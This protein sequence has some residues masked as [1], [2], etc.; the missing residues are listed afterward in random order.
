MSRPAFG[1][2]FNRLAR[3][4]RKSI[5]LDVVDELP[6]QGVF[7]PAGPRTRGAPRC[8]RS[9]ARATNSARERLAAA[10]IPHVAAPA[11][12]GGKDKVARKPGW[13]SSSFNEPPCRRMTALARL[14]PRPKPGRVLLP[15]SRTKRSSTRSRS[16]PECPAHGRRPDL[17]VSVAIGARRDLDRGQRRSRRCSA[18]SP[19]GV[20]Q[21]IVDEIGERLAGELAIA[22]RLQGSPAP[23]P[24]GKRRLPRRAAHR[25]RRRN[26]RS[27]PH[28]IAPCSRPPAR[29][30]RARSS[31]AR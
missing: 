16:P 31:R 4:A 1:P 2:G 14:K 15:S 6:G 12:G 10:R 8:A 20:F 26:A 19:L 28:R 27:R 5:V 24:R 3:R 30:P 9:A 13:L 7:P 25:A 23:R 18:A 29:L 17:G 11:N 22:V 21:G